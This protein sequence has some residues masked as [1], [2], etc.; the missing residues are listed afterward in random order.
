MKLSIGVYVIGLI[1][2]LTGMAS[3]SFGSGQYGALIYFAGL[4]LGVGL[5]LDRN[6]ESHEEVPN[7]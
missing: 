5:L 2:S 4:C 1:A 3:V 7:N 6:K